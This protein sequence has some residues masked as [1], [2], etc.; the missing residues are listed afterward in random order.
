MHDLIFEQVNQQLGCAIHWMPLGHEGTSNWLYQGSD[1]YQVLVLR[2]NARNPV[3]FG[4]C[5]EREA[6]V[7]QQLHGYVWAA[8]VVCS[9]P[10]LGW[11]VMKHHGLGLGADAMGLTIRQRLLNVVTELQLIQPSD[12]GQALAE[13][14]IRYSDL[15]Q[16]YQERLNRMSQPVLW[17]ERLSRLI[18]LFVSLPQVT[19][20]YTHHDLHPGN[21]CW[22]NG[23]LV[24]IDW[25]YAGIGNPWFDAAA[26]AQ[27]CSVPDAEIH[28][29]PAFRPLSVP[30]FEL[31]LQQAKD[32]ITLLDMLW[33]KVRGSD[34]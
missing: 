22:Q 21:L 15:F 34:G 1:G 19:P 14:S 29:L 27:Y 23:Q 31:G 33:Y 18:Q 2:V 3:A 17:L 10:D 4:V 13:L 20:C 9:R 28:R 25:E 8:Q 6:F 5:R 30:I 16:F 11:C 24:L 12:A 32:A 7:L 26:L